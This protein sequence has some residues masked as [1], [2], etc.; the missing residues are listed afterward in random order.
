MAKKK[1]N[2]TNQALR[3]VGKAASKLTIGGLASGVVGAAGV[4]AK[5]IDKRQQ[6]TS[7]AMKKAG[8]GISRAQLKK[9][10]AKDARKKAR[11]KKK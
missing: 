7:K 3:A 1:T 4:A 5:A 6:A 2:K 9:L 10:Q 8:K 11:K